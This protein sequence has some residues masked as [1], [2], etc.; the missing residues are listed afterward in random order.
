MKSVLQSL[1]VWKCDKGVFTKDIEVFDSSFENL[2]EHLHI[3]EARFF[4]NPSLPD[5]LELPSRLFVFHLL[6]TGKEFGKRTHIESALDIILGEQWVDAPPSLF[7]LSGQQ[8]Q[9]AEGF[10]NLGS[11]GMLGHTRAK[12]DRPLFG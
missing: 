10:Y 4:W 8:S 7:C 3:G 1:Q 11:I 2:I 6:I 12:D 9:V 5:F